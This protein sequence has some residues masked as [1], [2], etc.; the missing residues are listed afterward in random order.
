M[1]S[2]FLYACKYSGLFFLSKYL[3]RKKLLIL[4]Y[5]GFEIKNESQFRPQLFIKKKT[6]ERRLKILSNSSSRVL[7]LDRAIQLLAT[8]SLPDNSV[9][10]TIDD[11]FYSVLSIAFPLL[12]QYEFPATLYL[13]TKDMLRG[14]PILHLLIAYM[15]EITTKAFIS[16]QHKWGGMEK[17][18]LT[19][20]QDKKKFFDFCLSFTQKLDSF[21]ELEQFCIELGELLEVDYEE[22]RNSRL[23]TL[24]SESEVSMLASEGLD[25]QLHT[26]THRFP[27][28]DAEAASLEIKQNRQI[29]ERLTSNPL[30]HFCY[31][32]GQWSTSHWHILEKEGVKSATTCMPGLNDSKVN[33]LALHRFLDSENITDIVFEAELYR[34]NELL[35]MLRNMV[36]WN[37]APA[38]NVADRE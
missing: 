5:H 28:N 4:C 29:L 3:L 20:P 7:G 27:Q 21:E 30:V 18:E 26:H 33:M 13:T 10:I 35:R 2:F 37:K 11:G 25:I 1:K 6:F 17:A 34:F 15:I 23:V 24:L 19:R 8:D 9:A 31:P 14:Q 32:S 36:R 16:S 38:G 22:V 12:K